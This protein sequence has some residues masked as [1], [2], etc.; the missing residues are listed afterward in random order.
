MIPLIVR[1][2]YSLM[3]GT[4]YVRQVC[5]AAKC[6][7]YGRLALTDTDNLYGL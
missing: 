2:S 3:W 4:A 5:L 6:L 1:S 7:G